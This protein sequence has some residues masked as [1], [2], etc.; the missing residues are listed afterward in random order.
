VFGGAFSTRID[1]DGDDSADTSLA[2]KS[3]IPGGVGGDADDAG[4]AE[5]EFDGEGVGGYLSL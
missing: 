5:A 2:L 3:S 4:E 1:R